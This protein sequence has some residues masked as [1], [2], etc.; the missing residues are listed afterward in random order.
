MAHSYVVDLP[1]FQGPLDLLLHLVRRNEMDI[2]D[3]PIAALAGQYMETLG[4]LENL[5]LEVAG[6]FLVMASTLLEIKSRMLLPAPPADPD[7]G[8]PEDPRAELTRRLLEYQAFKT[9]ADT[10]R[11]IETWNVR[12][13]GRGGVEIL[14]NY[15]VPG[16]MYRNG[17]VDSLMAALQRML[18]E[19]A[20]DLSMPSPLPRDRWTIPI[21][22][23]ELAVL[24]HHN[25]DGV[26]FRET[27]PPNADRMEIIV[28][29]LALLEML[30]RG[31]IRLKQRDRWGDIR[32]LAVPA[33]DPAQMVLAEAMA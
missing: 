30:K 25:P 3:I 20:S 32:L 18:E 1:V 6:E 12:L 26:W 14:S 31:R 21:K 19:A 27:I 15:A 29:F 23:R 10:L 16:P 7:S 8:E 5:D 22:M 24:L 13:F 17:T 33:V 2:Y 28:T 11:G 9:A 4:R